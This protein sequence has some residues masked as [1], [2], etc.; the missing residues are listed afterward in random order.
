MGKKWTTVICQKQHSPTK[1]E[2]VNI[3]NDSLNKSN[4]EKTDC[5]YI[6]HQSKL[7]IMYKNLIQAS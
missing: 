5:D 2:S 1:R 6:A 4:N 3:Q 7:K